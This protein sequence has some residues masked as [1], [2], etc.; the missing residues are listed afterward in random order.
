MRNA[1]EIYSAERQ[2]P[3]LHDTL[4]RYCDRLGHRP[5][6]ALYIADKANG[7]SEA[8]AAWHH[9]FIVIRRPAANPYA[10]QSFAPAP[11][12]AAQKH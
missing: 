10:N 5:I 12:A 2:L 11:G 3:E 7:I 4:V 8:F 6:P 9:E 1:E